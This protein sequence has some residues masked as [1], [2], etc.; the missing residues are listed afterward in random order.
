MQRNI[1][2]LLRALEKRADNLQIDI[3]SHADYQEICRLLAL[4]DFGEPVTYEEKLYM[5]NALRD[6]LFPLVKL[7]YNIVYINLIGTAPL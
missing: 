2:K 7:D 3:D 5:R 4:M 6:T 1:D